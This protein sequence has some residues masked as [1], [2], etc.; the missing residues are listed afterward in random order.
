MQEWLL[1]KIFALIIDIF[2][3]YKWE[4][5]LCENI[6]VD[7]YHL[8]QNNYSSGEGVGGKQTAVSHF[9][10]VVWKKA[11][12]IIIINK[13]VSFIWKKKKIS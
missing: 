3:S 11:W 6:F 10:L 9:K 1:R 5:F 2:D 7:K 13:N 8:L 4:F 12:I